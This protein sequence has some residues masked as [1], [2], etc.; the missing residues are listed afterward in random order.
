MRCFLAC[1]RSWSKEIF[2]F[3]DPL[4]RGVVVVIVCGGGPR[5]EVEHFA[6]DV[7]Y[8]QG[9]CGK[10]WRGDHHADDSQQ[11]GKDERGHQH[12]GGM[13]LQRSRHDARR[14]KVVYDVIYG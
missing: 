10:Q 14:D 9:D 4:R 13:H 1:F 12:G 11:V 7:S 8:K 5:I 2:D 3:S 6:R